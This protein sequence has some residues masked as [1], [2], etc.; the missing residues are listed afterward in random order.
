MLW[1]DLLLLL[2]LV[3]G[4]DWLAGLVLVAVLPGVVVALG[5]VAPGGGWSAGGVLKAV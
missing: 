5:L 3:L 1:Q 2:L 4:A